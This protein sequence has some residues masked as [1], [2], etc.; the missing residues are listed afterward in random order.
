MLLQSLFG[1]FGWS[2]SRKLRHTLLTQ[3]FPFYTFISHLP[4]VSVLYVVCNNNKG[5][6]QT[7]R[8]D[9]NVSICL[10][11]V[12]RR[13]LT[14]HW[15]AQKTGQ[16]GGS[17]EERENEQGTRC[18]AVLLFRGGGR[19][20]YYIVRENGKPW[21]SNLMWPYLHKNGNKGELSFCL[22]TELKKFW[23]EMQRKKCKAIQ[24]KP[25]WE[26]WLWG[27]TLK[28]GEWGGVFRFHRVPFFADSVSL[29]TPSMWIFSG[30]K[31]FN[32]EVL[33]SFSIIL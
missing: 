8:N 5:V 15:S 23:K 17:G 2:V 16:D 30:R 13:D 1:G 19:N 26:Y 10:V 4:K 20:V 25:C 22:W 24:H 11:N 21:N 12:W 6:T 18:A 14:W 33:P 9:L 28:F 7:A 32:K 31:L 27:L 3:S 29:F